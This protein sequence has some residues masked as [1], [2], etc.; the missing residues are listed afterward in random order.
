MP[1]FLP[2]QILSASERVVSVAGISNSCKMDL[3]PAPK[4]EDS[5][6]TS[7]VEVESVDVEEQY[8]LEEN[9]SPLELEPIS[10]DFESD[11][12][13]ADGWDDLSNCDEEIQFLRDDEIRDGLGM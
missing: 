11:S 6:K 8:R 9:A 5:L 12:D 7:V 4:G 2:K 1:E 3:V 10:S 13:D